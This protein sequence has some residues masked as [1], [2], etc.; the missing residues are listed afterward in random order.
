MNVFLSFK[1]FSCWFYQNT[2]QKMKKK[3]RKKEADSS[4][5]ICAPHLDRRRQGAPAFL[6]T[7][8]SPKYCVMD[9]MLIWA[10][11]KG[12]QMS[13]SEGG[14]VKNMKKAVSWAIKGVM[15]VQWWCFL[16]FSYAHYLALFAGRFLW[17]RGGG[18][19]VQLFL[20]FHCKMCK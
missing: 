13:G 7:K 9:K 1:L 18:G 15:H 20:Y 5:L 4:I 8:I 17:D 2:K 16:F 6:T 12:K 19:N 10:V 3:Y 11:I 14:E